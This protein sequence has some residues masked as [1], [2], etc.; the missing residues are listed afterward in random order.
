MAR[1]A[2]Q[3]GYS[4]TGT[5]LACSPVVGGLG[6]GDAVSGSTRGPGEQQRIDHGEVSKVP[7]APTATSRVPDQATPFSCSARPVP[8]ETQLDPSREVCMA[9]V[10]M[11]MSALNPTVTN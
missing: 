10:R 4:S 9:V 8:C 3:I 6:G 2:L 1:T 11:P 7:A 5:L